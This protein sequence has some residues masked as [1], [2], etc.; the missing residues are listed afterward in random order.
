MW[1]AVLMGGCDS[2]GEL[3]HH[4]IG[5]VNPNP[6]LEPVVAGFKARLAEFGYIEGKNITYI[7]DRSL[8]GRG[9]LDDA[10][11]DLIARKIDL[12]FTLTTPATKRA[13]QGVDSKEVPIV[14]APV[15]YPVK[16][17]IVDSL[18]HPHKNF[19][20]VKIGGSSA[21]ALEWLLTAAPSVKTVL[22]P[23]A[24]NDEAATYSLEDLQQAATK[25]GI[26]LVVP[27]VRTVNDLA[28]KLAA[29]PPEVDALWLLNSNFLVPNIKLFVD[30]AIRHRLP[31][32]SATSQYQAGVMIS[33]AQRLER[34]GQQA[35]RLAHKILQ[36]VSPEDLPVETADFFLGLNLRTANAAGVQIPDA[37]LRQAQDIVR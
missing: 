17:G 7:Q 1:L 10:I 12:L 34:T 14:F 37:M 19:T 5:I 29:P 16:S 21:K 15:I 23:V 20:G 24:D 4:T 8:H 3:S 18:P 28:T 2:G 6:N 25:L 36:G 35:G 22:V 30:A 26:A 9:K 27:N 33:Y 32:A 13:I 31:L 11:D